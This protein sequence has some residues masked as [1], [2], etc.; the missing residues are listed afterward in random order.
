[1][2]YR[3]HVNATRARKSAIDGRLEQHELTEAAAGEYL[4]MTPKALERLRYRG[5]GPSYLKDG[6]FVYYHRDDL[7]R[8]NEDR[9]AS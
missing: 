1:M 3:L 6:K 5:G 2:A 4:G 8:W 9:R 7:D